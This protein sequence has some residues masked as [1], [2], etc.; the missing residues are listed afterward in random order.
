MATNTHQ[1]D[2]THFENYVA[3]K[4]E[5]PREEKIFFSRNSL[6]VLDRKK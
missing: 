4:K 5:F 1:S 3:R 2:F 6:C